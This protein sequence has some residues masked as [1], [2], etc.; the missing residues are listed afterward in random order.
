MSIYKKQSKINGSAPALFA[1]HERPGALERLTP[2]WMAL[3]SVTA[4]NG[5]KTGSQVRVNLSVMGLPFAMAAE[6]LDY[7]PP[8][9]FRDRLVKS[10]F[11]KWTHTHRFIDLEDN[12]S[13]LEDSISYDVPLYFPKALKNL[14]ERE[15]TRMF[16][17]RHRVTQE[18]MAR[19]KA[20]SRRLTIVVS[21]AGGVIGQQLCYFLTTGGHRVI[22]LV[23]RSLQVQGDEIFWNPA[24]GQLDLSDAGPIDAVIN[25]NGNSVF[26]RWWTRKRRAEII[27]SRTDST[28]TLALGLAR[29][30]Q[31][32]KVFISASAVGYYGETGD[33]AVT[34]A[35]PQGNL[36]ISKVCHEW[37]RAAAPA[38]AA[39]IR[40][41]FARIGVALTP[42]G[43]ALA[44]LLPAFQLGLGA[45]IANGSQ[46]MSW[47]SMDD[48][49]YA[50]YHTIN[51]PTLEGAVNI[52][53]PIPVTNRAFTRS[54]AAILG[55][56]APFALPSGAIDL[57]WGARGREVLLSSTRVM[58]E[59]L[60]ASGFRFRYADLFDALGSALGI[61]D[62]VPTNKG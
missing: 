50:L 57:L 7:Q 20:C 45:R 59:K 5:I 14:A 22:R 3:K 52:V 51:T 55:R 54:L 38:S 39:G 41:V 32:P 28:R 13:T 33:S 62:K 61:F 29:L 35:S 25:L 6:H 10:P 48:V 47:V 16:E 49:L 53:A 2:P 58:P 37:E 23:R 34:E 15:V 36:F 12:T 44:Q 18:D 21:G 40:T 27:Q 46:Y 19:H 24:A 4:T 42:R 26:S 60:L 30:A 11:A 8:D 1:W 17:F 9:M 56:P 31:P 43:G